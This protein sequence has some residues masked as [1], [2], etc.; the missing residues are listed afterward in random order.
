MVLSVMTIGFIN[1]YAEEGEVE[2]EN[3]CEEVGQGIYNKETFTLSFPENAVIPDFAVS[4]DSSGKEVVD[5][6]WWNKP[7][8]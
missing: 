3:P 7:Y 8:T 1:V 5:Y 6:P 2:E 4:K